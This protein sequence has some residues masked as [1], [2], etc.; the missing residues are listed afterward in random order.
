[1]IERTLT[2]DEIKYL[3]PSLGVSAQKDID[4][5]LLAHL[6]GYITSL[7]AKNKN[8][9]KSEKIAVLLNTDDARVDALISDVKAEQEAVEQA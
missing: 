9:E 2:A 4:A 6:D 8:D 5:A 1:M 7:V 3:A